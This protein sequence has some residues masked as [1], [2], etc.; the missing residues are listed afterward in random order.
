MAKKNKLKTPDW[1][2]EG[3][4]SPEDYNKAKGIT[5]SKKTGN[6]FKIR[7]CPKCGS[8]EVTVKLVGEEGKSA[9]EWECKKCKW[10]G[11]NIKKQELTEEEFMIYLDKKGEEVA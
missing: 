10:S 4:D 6:I 5:T 1:I 11:V 7:E 2:T 9:N 3:Y 8:D